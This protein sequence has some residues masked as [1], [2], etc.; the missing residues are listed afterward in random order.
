MQYYQEFVP[1]YW[2]A[3]NI[4][5]SCHYS[6]QYVF[7]FVERPCTVSGV[8]LSRES[9]SSWRVREVSS[10]SGGSGVGGLW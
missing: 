10:E 6:Y 5:Y 7:V 8:S 2:I 1:G 3:H 9:G 4:M